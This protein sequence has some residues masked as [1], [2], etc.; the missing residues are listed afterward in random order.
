MIFEVPLVLVFSKRISLARLQAV[1]L[2]A[3]TAKESN[4]SQDYNLV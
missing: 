3:T 2:I 4:A 1:F